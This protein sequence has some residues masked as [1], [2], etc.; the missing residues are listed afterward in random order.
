MT[1]HSLLAETQRERLIE[2]AEREMIAFEQKEREF[3]R[4][5]RQ[6]RAVELGLPIAK[7]TSQ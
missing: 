3:R 6:E 7:Y 5:A 4:Q 2:V 1:D